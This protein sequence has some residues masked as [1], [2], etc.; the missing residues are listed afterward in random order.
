M[1]GKTVLA[2]QTRS[3]KE[4]AFSG[5]GVTL[6]IDINMELVLAIA[7]GLRVTG[8][9]RKVASFLESGTHFGS[10]G[11]CLGSGG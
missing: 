3:L 5:I 6:S 8:T 10:C 4:R 7:S 11:V 2:S 9:I 1:G